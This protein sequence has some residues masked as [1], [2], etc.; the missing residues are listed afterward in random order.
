MPAYSLMYHD[1]VDR[2]AADA[3]GFAG[4]AAALYKLDA[5]T[6][7]EH[8]AAIAKAVERAGLERISEPSALELH[9]S[10]RAGVVLHFDDGGASALRA[11]EAI[12]RHGFRGFFHI[13]TDRIGTPGFVTEA[14]LRE[15]HARGHVVGSHSCS[16]PPR[17]SSLD[18]PEMLR[19]WS[20]SIARLREVLGVPVRV[21]SVPGGYSSGRVVAAAERAG[22]EVLFDSEPLSGL[23]RHGRCLVL[24][25]YAVK[26]DTRAEEVAAIAAG[27]RVPRLRQWVAWNAKK[28]LKRV[29]GTHWLAL[30]G[31]LLE[32]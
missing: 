25:R 5:A 10:G 24:G 9:G 21:G 16:H 20:E 7:D 23:R 13:T 6:F 19:Q 22:I 30:R 32:R 28:A 3:S 29:G 2:G 15:L 8:L 26:R 18:W 12:E 11:A 1:V 17:I 27:S 31:R 4:G 14:D